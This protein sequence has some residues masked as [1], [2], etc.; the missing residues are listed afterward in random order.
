[1]RVSDC[2]KRY[3]MLPKR[4]VSRWFSIAYFPVTAE[5]FGPFEDW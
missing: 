5:V 2:S 1:M 4:L 3:R